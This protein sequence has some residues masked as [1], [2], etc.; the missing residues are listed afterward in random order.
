[1]SFP[2]ACWEKFLRRLPAERPTG[3]AGRR[4]L[5]WHFRSVSPTWNMVGTTSG[6]TRAWRD[7]LVR[8]RA[9]CCLS[10][11]GTKCS[12]PTTVRNFPS[13]VRLVPEIPRRLI[14]HQAGLWRRATTRRH[15]GSDPDLRTRRNYQAVLKHSCIKNVEWGVS[16]DTPPTFQSLN[17]F[18]H[19]MLS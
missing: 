5:F 16:A 1:M 14:A 11:Q 19:R 6:E 12:C 15:S 3:A 4:A 13:K 8:D 2:W 9:G 10:C 18:G 7:A 17:T